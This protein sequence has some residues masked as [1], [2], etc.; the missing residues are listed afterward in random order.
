M[1]KKVSG[2]KCVFVKLQNIGRNYFPFV[3]D[4]KDRTI[5]YLDV[6]PVTSLPYPFINDTPVSQFDGLYVCVADKQGNQYPIYALPI[7]RLDITKNMG[8]RQSVNR[9]ISMSDSY[10]DCEDPALVGQVVCF[11]VWYDL[12]DYSAPDTTPDLA[13]DSV[14]VEI[15]SSQNNNVFPDNRTMAGR[16]FRR[17][18][19]PAVSPTISGTT[20]LSKSEMMDCYVSFVKG[21]YAVIDNVPLAEFYDI[22]YIYDQLCFANICFDFTNSFVTVGGTANYDGRMVMFNLTYEN[23]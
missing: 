11:V 9:Q 3:E 6:V 8:R 1:L 17:I 14:E 10:V 15:L 22:D 2:A 20:G 4:L 21:N 7:D 12:V 19:F 5:R 16:R 13:I 23:K 18:S